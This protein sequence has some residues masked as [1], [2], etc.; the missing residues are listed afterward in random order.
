MLRCFDGA[1]FAIRTRSRLHLE[2]E[3]ALM[4]SNL[5]LAIVVLALVMGAMVVLKP[6]D[7]VSSAASADSK[8]SGQPRLHVVWS[9]GPGPW[10]L[11]VVSADR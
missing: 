1:H 4:N 7:A 3:N 6:S 10:H 2:L 11:P 8:R 9:A 5:W